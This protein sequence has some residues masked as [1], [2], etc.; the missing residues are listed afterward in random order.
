MKQIWAPWRMDYILNAGKGGCFLC[1]IFAAGADEDNLVLSRGGRCALL[2]N[3]YPYNNG[4]LMVAPFRHVASLEEMDGEE[5]A[6]LMSMASA[7][8]AALRAAVNPDGFNVGINIGAAAGAGLKDHI[9]MH[10]VPRWRG[11]TNFMP[12]V[13]DVKV[14]PQSLRELWGRIKEALS[15]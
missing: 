3:L 4:H 2:M 1:E 14:I 9:H 7:A 15:A 5:L 11:D 6:E 12:V 13:A 10:I 8:C